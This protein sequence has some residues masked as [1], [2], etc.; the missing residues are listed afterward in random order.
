LNRVSSLAALAGAMLAYA[1]IRQIGSIVPYAMAFS[2][3]G[4]LY[5]A[6]ADVIPGHRHDTSLCGVIRQFVMVGAGIGT[7]L[8]MQGLVSC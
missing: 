1:G 4:F 6:L 2:A 7:I 8:L 3:A 5:V